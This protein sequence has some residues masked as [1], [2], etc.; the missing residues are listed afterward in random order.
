M[1]PDTRRTLLAAGLLSLLLAATPLQGLAYDDGTVTGDKGSDMLIDLVVLRPLGAV[2]TVVGAAVWVVALPFTIPTGQ[3]AESGRAMVGRPA[4][5]T[6][7]RPLGDF[8]RCG[9]DRHWC[10][11]ER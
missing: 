10:G 8:E 3:V 4:E 7:N 11:S 6:F 5:Y 2:T 1:K 9:A